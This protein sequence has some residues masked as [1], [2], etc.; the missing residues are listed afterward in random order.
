MKRKTFILIIALTAILFY[1]CKKNEGSDLDPDRIIFSAEVEQESL[2]GGMQVGYI[3]RVNGSFYVIRDDTGEETN[4]T[5][6]TASMALGER[7]YTGEIR[8][9]TFPT[10]GRVYDF[11]EVRRENGSDGFAFATHVAVGGRL[12]VV[13]DDRAQL[14]RSPKSIDVSGVILSRRTVVVYYP[15]TED[16]GFVE[17]RAYDS[18]RQAY[19]TSANAYV[20]S[21][22]LSTRDSDIQSSI[23]LQT[24]LPLSNE[25]QEKVRKDALLESALYSYPDSVFNAEIQEL[26][27]PS[28]VN[29]VTIDS[30][31]IRS[32]DNIVQAIVTADNVNV[33]DLPDVNHGRVAGR[34][35][36]GDMV[37]INGQTTTEVTIGGLTDFW[38]R[39]TSP[40]E[41][42][43]FG[44]YLED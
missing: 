7:V 4:R 2:A 20:R 12:A 31:N 1:S 8:R 5:T 35:N 18:V 24:A 29:Q 28:A 23:L 6:W 25:G 15:E 27:N 33:R 37:R 39:I 22:S 11:I 13:V 9:A 3:L 19:V 44:A 16:G 14:H 21:S 34:V 10:D 41:G 43:V 42:W 32:Y 30:F 38:Y 26:V 17:V 36:E 40:Y